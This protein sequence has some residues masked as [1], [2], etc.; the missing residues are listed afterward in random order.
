MK[1]IIAGAREG[2]TYLDIYRAMQRAAESGITPSEVI[3]GAC[4]WE[5]IAYARAHDPDASLPIEALSA[6]MLGER[7]ATQHG[8]DSSFWFA[9]WAG[10]GRGAGPQRNARMARAG[11]ALVLVWTG[12]SKGSASMLREACRECLQIVDVRLP[13]PP[14]ESL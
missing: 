12:Q 7:W 5:E 13:E 11:E 10:A 6:D 9:D 8:I 4:R 1:T 3:C 14:R 2:V